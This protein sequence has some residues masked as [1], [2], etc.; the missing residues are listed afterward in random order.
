MTTEQKL[1][2]E[3]PRIRVDRVCP[4]CRFHGYH[5]GND[6]G[7]KHWISCINCGHEWKGRITKDEQS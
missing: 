7:R 6:M 4:R 5:R 2:D 3:P 1:R